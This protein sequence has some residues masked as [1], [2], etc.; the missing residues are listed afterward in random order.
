[1]AVR[2]EENVVIGAEQR[3]KGVVRFGR[4]LPGRAEPP[5]FQSFPIDGGLL[6]IVSPIEVGH[7]A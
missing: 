5:G 4:R 6:M 1:M 2:V 7:H 3:V